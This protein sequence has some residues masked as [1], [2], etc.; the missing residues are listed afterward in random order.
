M[1][2]SNDYDLVTNCLSCYNDNF[3]VI[4]ILEI[5]GNDELN[6][7]YT[8]YKISYALKLHT[9]CWA[10][11]LSPH[12]CGPR[13][14]PIWSSLCQHL[15]GPTCAHVGLSQAQ[16]HIDLVDSTCVG[17]PSSSP[18]FLLN[19]QNS[20]KFLFQQIIFDLRFRLLIIFSMNI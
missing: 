16:V 6:K 11:L 9:F 20:H 7:L 18:C 12:T 2:N 13:S 17:N 1:S 4:I 19:L 10:F 3:L 8:F 15:F 5:I 14:T